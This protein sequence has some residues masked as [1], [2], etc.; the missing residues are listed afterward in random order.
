MVATQIRPP[1]PPAPAAAA[2][3]ASTSLCEV[4]REF[5]EAQLR[6]RRNAT[7]IYQDLVD[8]HGFTGA[9][10]SVKRFVSALRHKEPEQFDRLS[11]LP[12]QGMQVDYGEGAL[13]LA[14]M[15]ESKRMAA[16]NRVL[17][18]P[19]IDDIQAAVQTHRVPVIVAPNASLPPE[20]IKN[21]FKDGIILRNKASICF[22]CQKSSHGLVQHMA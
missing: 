17:A 15:Y 13:T 5:I 2:A 10:N 18:M 14:Q 3:A 11:F 12:G 20:K 4:R 8:L 7:A 22:G 6:L 9:Y 16:Y 21:V 1:W 19:K